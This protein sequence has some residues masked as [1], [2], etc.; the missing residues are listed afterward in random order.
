MTFLPKLGTVSKVGKFIVFNSYVLGEILDERKLMDF[1]GTNLGLNGNQIVIRKFRHG[2]S[3]PTYYI[4]F[5]GKELV[6]RKK[7][8]RSPSFGLK[9]CSER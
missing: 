8:V 2:Q 3:N 9:Y 4:K 6:L 1:L 5:A 7:P